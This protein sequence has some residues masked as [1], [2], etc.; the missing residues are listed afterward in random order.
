[1]LLSTSRAFCR[2]SGLT[3]VLALAVGG[4]PGTLL[5]Q[6]PKAKPPTAS[7]V[8]APQETTATYGDWVL[9]CARSG[10]VATADANTKTDAAP[11]TSCEVVQTITTDGQT[12]PVAKLAFG[13]PTMEAEQLVVTAVLPVNVALPGRVGLSGNGKAGDEER[14]AQAL[15]WSACLP[16][17]CYARANVEAGVIDVARKE[18]TGALRFVS[19]QGQTVVITLSWAGFA[20]AITALDAYVKAH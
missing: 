16:G 17:G 5:A 3:L 9:H 7:Q 1:M 6:T 14:G 13:Y 11:T 4:A 15:A 20:S 10:P 12:A 2:R 8:D 18:K 19:A